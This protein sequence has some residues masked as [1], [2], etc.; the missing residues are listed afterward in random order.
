[1]S[2]RGGWGEGGS[3]EVGWE[4]MRVVVS[5]WGGKG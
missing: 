3:E 4:E 5:V 1:M 2:G